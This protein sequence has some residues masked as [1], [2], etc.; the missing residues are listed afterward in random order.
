MWADNARL[1]SVQRY[2]DFEHKW[3][4]PKEGRG[5]GIALFWKASINLEVV[6]AI[7]IIY[8]SIKYKVINFDRPLHS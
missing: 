3:L 7:I 5:R 2:I 6:D 4:V 1:E 8:K